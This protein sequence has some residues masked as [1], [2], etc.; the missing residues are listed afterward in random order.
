MSINQK[1]L[2][3]VIRETLGLDEEQKQL[4]ESYVT[5]AKVYKLK[6]DLLSQKAIAA[7]QELLQK[8]VETLNEISARLDSADRSAANANNSDYRSLKIDEAYNMNAA[9]L[10][11]YF[12]DNIADTNS[13][14]TMD[15]LAYMRIARDFGTFDEW[16]KDFIAC[17]MSARNGWAMT[18]Y[19][20]FLDRYMNICI[21]LHSLNVPMNCYPVIVVDMWEHSYFR[22]Y[23]ADKQKYT[24]AMMKEFDWEVIE[25]RFERAEKLSK[26]FSKPLGG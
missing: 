20:G 6:T 13:K 4:A 24:F 7:H 1:E 2:Q 25:K 5:Q 8:Y 14:I 3:R 22:D 18:V 17:A 23:L 11:A 12:F 21:D 10:H 15:S 16:Q 9:F 19:N 26:V